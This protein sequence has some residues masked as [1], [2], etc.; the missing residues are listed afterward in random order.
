[1]PQGCSRILGSWAGPSLRQALWSLPA[2]LVPK[3]VPGDPA[4]QS[5][6]PDQLC[7]P[8]TLPA[9]RGCV[10]SQKWVP[11]IPLEEFTTLSHPRLM[12]P[13]SS[14]SLSALQGSPYF[15]SQSASRFQGTLAFTEQ[16]PS[17]QST[18]ALPQEFEGPGY[19]LRA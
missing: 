19:W 2:L 8:H 16:E 3:D 13:L 9:F 17:L 18:P 6:R 4:S 14:P 11:G 12:K 10:L 7:Y 1:M 5:L 15:L